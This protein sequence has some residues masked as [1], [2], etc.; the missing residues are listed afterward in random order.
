MRDDNY[1]YVDKTGLA[2]KLAEQ[3]KYVFLSRPRRFGK[4]LFLDTLKEMFEGNERLFVGLAADQ[5]YDWQKRYPVI[6]LSFAEGDFSSPANVQESISAQIAINEKRLGLP[7]EQSIPA[8]R[9]GSLIRNVKE[10]FTL[11]VVVLVDEYDKP[12]LDNIHNP[13]LAEQARNLLRGLY[14][15]L[16]ANAAH[17]RFVFLTGVSK[18]SKVSIFS[19]LNNLRDISLSPEYGTICGYTHE[20]LQEHFAPYLDGVDMDEV[21]AWY[22]GYNFRG[23]NV[24]NP[25]DILLFL[26]NNKDFASYWFETG[27]PSVLVRMIREK[28]FFLPD[29]TRITV[30][31]E[32]LNSFDIENINLITMLFQTGYLTI[33][34]I[35]TLGYLR[36]YILD[37]P[38]LEVS[39]ALNNS[40]LSIFKLDGYETSALQMQGYAALLSGDLDAFQLTVSALFAAIPYHNFTGNEISRYEGFYASVLY[41][42][43]ASFRLVVR[44]EECTNKGR[45]DMSIELDNAVYIL[46]FKVDEQGAALGQIQKRGYAQKYAGTGREIFGVGIC[47]SSTERNISEFFWEKME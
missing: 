30:G 31:E 38:N 17:L 13:D 47:F 1:V 2:A 6:V 7:E 24:Y 46:E 28:Q 11:P 40:L 21:R 33:R 35:R 45:I 43:L 26:D 10:K 15:G 20:E 22:D 4:S 32:L 37:F 8:L 3:Y 23:E 9:L 29:L 19:G 36:Q 14:G 25:F 41:A 16:K 27:T 44:V 18:F 5:L 42:W 12:I 39:A 34:E